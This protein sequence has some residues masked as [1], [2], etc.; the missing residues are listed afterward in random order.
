[1]M[2]AGT[3]LIPA[4]VKN[5]S[6]MRTS[7]ANSVESRIAAARPAH[8]VI[9]ELPPELLR[10]RRAGEIRR[11]I[12]DEVRAAGIANV[13]LADNEVEA[14]QTLLDES[15]PGDIVLVLTH[16]DEAVRDLV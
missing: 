5:R 13:T 3:P 7:S 6:A 14:V 2:V 9:R 12:A 16:L 15:A 11:V 10:G 1:M 4:W 8:V